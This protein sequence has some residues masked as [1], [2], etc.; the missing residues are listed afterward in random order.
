MNLSDDTIN[1]FGGIGRLYGAE[2][3]ARYQ[4]AHVMII[5]IGG[6]GSWTAEA[7]A[8]SGVG[9]LTLVDLDDLCITNTNRQ[10]PAH[11]GNYGR[12]KA[13]ALAERIRLISPHC[14]VT[15]ELRFYSASSA[16][17]LLGTTPETAPTAVVD[18]IDAIKA[19]CHLLATCH[20]RGIPICTSGGAGGK[21]DATRITTADLAHVHGDKLLS[22]V[23]QRLRKEYHF[24]R[25]TDQKKPR[26][27]GIT[28][29]YSDEQM[30]PPQPCSISEGADPVSATDNT[31]RNLNC[32]TG[33]G[34]V[35]H[36]TATFGL[37][38]AQLT[39][40]AL[41]TGQQ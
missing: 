22:S 16:D 13:D 39:L 11:D 9:R 34:A 33:Y 14:E 5:G 40:D 2:A 4:S 38:L 1:R 20:Q 32:A 41:A 35:T 36:V 21:R 8:R 7:L 18:A 12:M 28:A 26:K 23:R 6:V 29:V 17:A 19:K 3:L 30:T 31:P 37:V 10:L 24:P 27:F 25:G 15:T